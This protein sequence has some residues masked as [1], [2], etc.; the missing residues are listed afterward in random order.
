MLAGSKRKLTESMSNVSRQSIGTAGTAQLL[1][2]SLKTCDS[3]LETAA[4]KV[5]ANIEGFDEATLNALRDRIV[6]LSK[7][8]ISS[9]YLNDYTLNV[10]ET[11]L[12]EKGNG[13]AISLNDRGYEAVARQEINRRISDKTK[14]IDITKDPSAKRIRDLLKMGL[15]SSSSVD[16]EFEVVEEGFKQ[17]DSICPFTKQVYVEP[18]KRY[19]V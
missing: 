15:A 14:S 19:A 10:L 5:K 9:R 13:Q 17:S 18:M 2:D 8:S 7:E 16:E 1:T 3:L 4:E 6:S 12:G 11:V